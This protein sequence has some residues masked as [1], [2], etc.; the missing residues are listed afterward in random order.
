MHIAFLNNTKTTGT[1]L[2]KLVQKE[3]VFPIIFQFKSIFHFNFRKIKTMTWYVII[4]SFSE[5]KTP[6]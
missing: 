6:L 3:N 2:G 5:I 4:V 1:K